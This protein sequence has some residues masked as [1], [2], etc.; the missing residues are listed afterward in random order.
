MISNSSIKHTLIYMALVFGVVLLGAGCSSNVTKEEPTQNDL[1]KA[2]AANL[3]QG[4]LAAKTR[5]RLVERQVKIGSFGGSGARFT[6]KTGGEMIDKDNVDEYLA[7]YQKQLSL[8]EE[9]IRQ[10]GSNDLSGMYQGE[11]TESCSRVNSIFAAAIQGQKQGAIEIRQNNMNAL[12]VV[13][14]LQDGGEFDVSNP[15]AVVESALAVIDAAN[16]DYY[17]RGQFNNDVIEIKADVSVL[18]TW[19]KWANPPSRRD[20]EKCIITL[21]KM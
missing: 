14:V 5:L 2:P 18:E 10:R 6:L 8:Y 3:A 15:A 7:K 17:F 21:K 19:P 9:A 4:Y 1:L 11:A 16:S 13:S 12:L 20:L